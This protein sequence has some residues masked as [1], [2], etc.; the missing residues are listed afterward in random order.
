M[1]TPTWGQIE[2][3]LKADGGWR[4]IRS[5]KHVFYEK[6][7]PDGRVLNTHVSHAKDKTPHRDTFALICRLQLQVTVDEFWNTV[8]TGEPARSAQQPPP[9]PRLPSLAMIQ[10]LRRKLHLTD[11]ELEGMTFDEAKRRLDEHHSRPP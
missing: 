5:T 1:R 8:D 6:T 3:F 2:A 4:P 7:L 11:P 10:E 9:T